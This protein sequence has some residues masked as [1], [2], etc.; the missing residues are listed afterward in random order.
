M[1]SA[2]TQAKPLNALKA[3]SLNP[4]TLLHAIPTTKPATLFKTASK[5]EAQR[6]SLESSA[7]MLRSAACTFKLDTS[8]TEEEEEE[9][10]EIVL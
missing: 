1:R 2:S 4:V 6:L 8:A 3:A 5:A 10:S 9:D 7:I